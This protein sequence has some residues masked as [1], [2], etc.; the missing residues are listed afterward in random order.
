M[1]IPFYTAHR[2]M[3]VLKLLKYFIGVYGA[4][5]MADLYHLQDKDYCLRD[6]K[7]GWTNLDGAT[8]VFDQMSEIY[9]L[10]LPETNWSL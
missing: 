1:K 6:T 2:P 10:I 9:Y 4:A 8:I 3:Q 7:I 5:T